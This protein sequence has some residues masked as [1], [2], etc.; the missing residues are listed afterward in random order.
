MAVVIWERTHSPGFSGKGCHHSSKASRGEDLQVEHPV[1]CGYSPTFHFHATLAG[2]P[3]P[4]LIRHQIIQVRE[5][6]QKCLLA[7]V[8]MM[9]PF[10]REQ[11]TRDGVVGLIQQGAGGGHLR[12]F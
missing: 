7:P 2:L 10:H 3:G 8:W 1:W 9:E 4:T 12:G 5:P 6:R 11:F